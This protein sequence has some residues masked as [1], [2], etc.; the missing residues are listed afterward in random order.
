MRRVAGRVALAL[1]L[2]AALVTW[3]AV[4]DA[5]IRA[6]ARDYVDRQAAFE[7]GR[8]PRADM[9][10]VMR[11]AAARGARSATLWTLVVLLP[12]VVIALRVRNKKDSGIR[13]QE[14]GS[15]PS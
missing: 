5:R 12:G 13:S 4:F 2:L 15:A 7:Q 11:A 1:W 6:G 3:N 10:A 8:G 9:D 14:S